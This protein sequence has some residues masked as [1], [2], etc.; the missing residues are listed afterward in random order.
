MH[1]IL[2]QNGTISLDLSAL[3]E[4]DWW[5]SRYQIVVLSFNYTLKVKLF[6][7]QITA[8]KALVTC[9]PQWAWSKSSEWHNHYGLF[10]KEGVVHKRRNP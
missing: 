9:E 3:N 10:K 1:L 4:P 2:V 7:A 5:R 8:T 6:A